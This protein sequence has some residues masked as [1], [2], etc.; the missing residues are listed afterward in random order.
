[1]VA[2]ANV[3]HDI[4]GRGASRW[5]AIRGSWRFAGILREAK[6]SC[7]VLCNL[8]CMRVGVSTLSFKGSRMDQCNSPSK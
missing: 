1:M 6:E 8:Y 4:K 2:I 5:V 7:M 3:P